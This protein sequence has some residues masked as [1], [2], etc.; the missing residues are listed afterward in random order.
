M[1]DTVLNITQILC[2]A[3]RDLLNSFLAQIQFVS[4][5]EGEVQVT[6]MVNDLGSGA[7]QGRESINQLINSTAVA[8]TVQECKLLRILLK[9]NF[10]L[11]PPSENAVQSNVVTAVAIA[12]TAGGVALMAAIIVVIKK[13]LN[14]GK[15]LDD[16]FHNIT[17]EENSV[18]MNPLYEKPDWEGANPFYETKT[19]YSFRVARE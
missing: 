8:F 16:F 7:P 10:A 13:K 15:H 9:L 1:N 4:P 17:Y 11:V 18:Q 12:T 6:I 2:V 3:K 5:V 14:H 19:K